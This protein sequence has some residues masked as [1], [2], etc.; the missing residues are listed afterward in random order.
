MTS[1]G[2]QRVL[3][4]LLGLGGMACRDP[5]AAATTSSGSTGES[6]EGSAST[7]EGPESDTSASSS[8]SGGEALV[9]E[10]EVVL[11]DDQPMVVDLLLELS[12]PATI[13]VQ[14]PFDPGVS[15]AGG[16]VDDTHWAFRVRGLAP[17]TLHALEYSGQGDAGTAS[18][19]IEFTTGAPLP[20]FLAQFEVEGGPVDPAMPYRMFDITPFPAFTSSSA[21]MVDGEG[22]TR[23]HFGTS[24]SGEAGPQ[25]LVTAVKLRTD[26]SFFY[27][28]LHEFWMR[29]ELTTTLVHLTD[30]MLGLT[31]MH[32]EVLELD[33]GNFMMLT[34][35]FR[36][37]TYPDDGELYVVGDAIVE[38]TAE[39]EVVWTWDTFDHLDP[40][41]RRTG[42]YPGLFAHPDTGEL[43]HDWTHGN[44]IEV[45]AE[46]NTLL[47]SMRHQDWIVK[48]DRETGE[49]L[50]RLGE[51]GDFT[52]EGG[53]RWFYH[54]HSPQWQPDG[55]LLL[56]D[57][58]VDNPNLPP[59]EVRSRAV[60]YAIDE[61]NM[62][63]TEVWEDDAEPF[64]SVFAGDADLLPSG[65]F[66]VT[67][68]SILDEDNAMWARIR[69]IDPDAMPMT[70]WA[71]TTPRGNFMY[72][73]T[74][75]DRL[76]GCAA[77]EASGCAGP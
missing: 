74:A 8:S 61:E 68:S 20:G 12:S 48:I 2:S 41:R 32:H 25:G 29:D 23:W 63:V 53:G 76:V 45:D 56:Y 54:Q 51:E 77:G 28:H 60:A 3:V 73:A 46:T 34:H 44:G 11:H 57:N 52:L 71:L 10:A 39:G 49:I 5:E 42:F 37:V 75:H 4:A 67:D 62:T 66:I 16:A 30:E 31:G 15:I 38:F 17:A 6:T 19:S 18:G 9:I 7:S 47:F 14:H 27:L 55:T 1:V 21:F 58:G 33:N 36:D 65:R 43:G 59:E 35:T 64:V 22:R 70:K 24:T 26:G 50:W 69:E 40:Q 72:R 13:E